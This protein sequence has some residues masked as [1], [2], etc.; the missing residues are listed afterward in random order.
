MF[1]INMVWVLI[2]GFL[3]MF[4][5]T[6]FMLVETGLCK[7]KREAREFTGTGAVLVNGKKAGSE[8]RLRTDDLLHGEFIALRRGKKNWHLM[9]FA[10]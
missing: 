8:D 1:S 9:R 6:G 5:Q 10:D 4:M 2:A 3:V 7:S